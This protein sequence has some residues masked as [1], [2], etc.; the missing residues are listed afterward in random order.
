MLQNFVSYFPNMTK[1]LQIIIASFLI[2]S[3]IVYAGFWFFYIKELKLERDKF[4]INEY[5]NKSFNGE[6]KS[7]DQYD[8]PYKIVLGIETN[9]NKQIVYGVICVNDEFNSFVS[10]GDSVTKKAPSEEISF[11]KKKNG[12]MR[13]FKLIFCD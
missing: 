1:I 9:F 8:P 4:Y 13:K 10:V 11:I 5:V 6:L 2:L 12:S 7:I 3:V